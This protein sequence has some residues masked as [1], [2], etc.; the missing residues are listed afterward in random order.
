MKQG[1]IQFLNPEMEWIEAA[2]ADNMSYSDFRRKPVDY[3][4]TLIAYLRVKK[5]L[6]AV[7]EYDS[8]KK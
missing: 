6:D 3:Q 8:R 2:H 1:Q 5:R 7:L 4:E